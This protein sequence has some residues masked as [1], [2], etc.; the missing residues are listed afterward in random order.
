MEN[1]PLGVPELDQ[2]ILVNMAYDDLLK[3]CQTNQYLYSICADDLFW[4]NKIIHDF[5]LK[6]AQLK[7]S[8]ITYAQQ[9]QELYRLLQDIYWTKEL[10]LEDK[11]G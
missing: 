11:K 1:F 8:E 5:N 4:K 10:P 2:Q 7:P 6:I 3:V 9:Y